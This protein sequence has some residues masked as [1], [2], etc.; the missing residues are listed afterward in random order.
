M[1]I[2]GGKLK[3][4]RFNPPKGFPSRPTT[5]FAKEGLFNILENEVSFSELDVLD[6]FAGTGNITFEFVSRGVKSIVSVDL[7]LRCVR[8]IKEFSK[9]YSYQQNMH[10]V[11][12]DALKFIENNTRS[13]D[14]IFADPPFDL[15]IHEKIVE[16]IMKGDFLNKKGLFILEHSKK[17]SFKEHP[18]FLRE[19]NYGGVV[20]SFFK[21]N[22]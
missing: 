7:N 19:R 17:D 12:A 16:K 13:Y 10:V 21:Q 14:L 15:D 3:G 2:I 4:H 1:R 9:E 22:T 11:K 6:L 18:D 20:F 5:D 8:F